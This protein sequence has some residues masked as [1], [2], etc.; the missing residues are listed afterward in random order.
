MRSSAHVVV[1]VHP[2]PLLMAILRLVVR[3]AAQVVPAGDK[4]VVRA[5]VD[6][7]RSPAGAYA[8]CPPD[9]FNPPS[10]TLV[11]WIRKP[12]AAAVSADILL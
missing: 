9:R 8:R 6:D 10:P 5:D 4:L 1:V 11:L 3:D 12:F 2:F 7:T